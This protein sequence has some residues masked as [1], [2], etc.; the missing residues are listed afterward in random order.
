M[1]RH[2]AEQG[3]AAKMWFSGIIDSST[4]KVLRANVGRINEPPDETAD[5]TGGN[6]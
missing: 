4:G 6:E 2:F 1:K 3:N 5:T